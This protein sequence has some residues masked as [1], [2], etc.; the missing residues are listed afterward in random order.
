MSIWN[1]WKTGDPLTDLVHQIHNS[2][3]R[4]LHLKLEALVAGSQSLSLA[5]AETSKVV[6]KYKWKEGGMVV[7]RQLQHL[8]V[9]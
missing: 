5:S 7:Y 6:L 4:L 3:L 8:P 9:V 1:T 2:L